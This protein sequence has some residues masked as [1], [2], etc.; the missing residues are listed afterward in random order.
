[1]LLSLYNADEPLTIGILGGGQLAKMTAQAAYRMGLRVA[2]IEHGANSPAGAMTKI[3]F[4][5]GWNSPEALEQF[6]EASDIVTLENEFIDVAILERIAERRPVFP[7]PETMRL[8]QDK[9]IQKTT[10]ANAGIPVPRFARIDTVEQG[11]EFG[12]THNYPFVMKT[13]THGYDGYG[14]MTVKRDNNVLVAFKKFTSDPDAPR[15]VMAEEFITFRKELAVI[16]ARNRRGE[17]VL[18]PCVETVQEN[19]ICR[20]V[21]APALI[22][23][24]LQKKAQEIALAAVEAVKGVG[25][26]GVEMFLTENDEILFNEIAPRPHNSGHYSIEGCYTSQFENHIRAV[27]NLP[28]GSGE[29]ITSA[30]VMLNLLGVRPGSGVPDTIVGLLQNPRVSLHLYGKKDSR[31]GRK[32]GHLT[33][34]GN[35]VE[36]AQERLIKAE[37]DLVW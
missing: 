9:L 29:L 34:I 18:Y 32:M 17:V 31:M 16:V 28:L 3:D 23:A 7:T 35:S 5:E 22:E 12:A 2:I 6:I 15:E 30:T 10:M 19:H 14:N 37:Q 1:M 21:L 4:P 13:R 36:D 20:W 8:A 11:Y 24:R 33:A 26:F 25:I 27:C